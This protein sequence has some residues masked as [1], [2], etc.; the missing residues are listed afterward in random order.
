LNLASRVIVAVAALPPVLGVVY[1]GGWWLFALTALAGV[2]AL[3]EFAVMARPLRP[4]VLAGYVGVI[5][6]LLGA[7]LSGTTWLLAAVLGTM[8]A[9]FVLQGLAGTRQ[10]ATVAIGSTLL[11]A[12]WIGLGLAHVMLLR[13]LPVHGRTAVFTVLLA[14]FA[15]DTVALF[16][17]RLVGRHK[18]APAISP[19]KTW[20]GFAAGT[21]AAVA[22]SF[23]ALYE[24]RDSFLNI[25]QALL[26]GVVVAV[27]AAAGD[28]FESAIKR[29]VGVKDSGRLL[30]GHGG[31]LDRVDAHLFAAPA[32]Y[33]LILA[34][35]HGPT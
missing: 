24:D 14:V 27:A 15:A 28:L 4:L 30:A 16:A 22:V 7:Q 1:L 19:G 17:G 11:G 12:V 33:Y 31:V 23:F 3:H 10:P 29:D 2:L 21:L 13:D 32:A 8:L 35:G 34:L 5:A 9:G 20:E 18:L 6:M 26:L 25:P